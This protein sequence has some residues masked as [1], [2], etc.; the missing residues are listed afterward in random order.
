MSKS[1]SRIL[2][3]SKRNLKEIVRDPIS[4]IFIILLPL[5]MELLFYLAFHNLT[6]QFQMKYLAPGIVI[7]SQSFLSLFTGLLI[8]VDRNS[9]FLTRLYVSKARSYEFI[10]GYILSVI[11]IVLV[12]SILFF[13]IG[14]IFDTSLFC[15][16]MIISIL[17]SV[18]TSF[19]FIS[20]GILFGS[21]CSERSIGGVAS[22][23]IN[24]QSLLSGMWFPVDGMSNGFITA[25][26]VLPFKN[27]IMIVQNPITGIN[28]SFKD[29]ILPFIIVLAYTIVAFVLAILVF[30][31]KMKEK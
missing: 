16:G 23:V 15:V 25:M 17:I 8:A 11:P 26:K 3:L 30:K 6:D 12:Q 24:A 27:A 22:I 18:I 13:I 14:G 21:I 29:F 19:F 9:T 7:F 10:I 28:D 2:T 1:I 5:F 20:L 31:N 4:L